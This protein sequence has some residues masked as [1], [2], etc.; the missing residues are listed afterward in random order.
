M[1]HADPAVAPA[2]W[3]AE[4]YDDLLADLLLDSTGPTATAETAD[5]VAFLVAQLGL[6]PGARVFDQCAGTGR[7]AVPLAA[8]GAEV[9][10][11][12]QAPHYVDRARAHAQVAGVADR[13]RFDVGDA[14]EYVPDRPCAGALNWWTSFGYLAADDA[15]ARMLQRAF[16]ALAPGGRFAIDYP[17]VPNLYVAFRP[18]EVTRRTTPAGE[19]ELIRNSHFDLARGL[20]HKQWTFTTPDGRRVER[21]STLRLYP[22]D[23]LVALL[24]DVGFTELESFGGTDGAPLALDRPRCI[25]V[26][27][28]PGARR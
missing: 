22:P 11:V 28:R 24:A 20:L 2:T 5:T 3:W 10:A 26:G 9:V 19:L 6:A 7:L 16:E 14:F 27:T 18:H 8:W 12:E 25:V 1:T 15:N 21:H 17:H 23:R 13:V 4:L